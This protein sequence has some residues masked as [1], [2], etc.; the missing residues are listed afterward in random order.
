MFIV[1]GFLDVIVM[2][3]V[4]IVLLFIFVNLFIGLLG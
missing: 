4:G 3:V 2:I 1:V